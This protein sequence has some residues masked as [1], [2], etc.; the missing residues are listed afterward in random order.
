M[1]GAPIGNTNAAKGRKMASVILKRLEE[2]KAM[3]DIADALINKAIDGDIP[4]IK[5]V[6]DRT[7]GKVAQAVNVGGQDGKNPIQTKWTIEIIEPKA[8]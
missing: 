7:D 2:R 5:E 6:L 1:A 8:K 3:E 4:A